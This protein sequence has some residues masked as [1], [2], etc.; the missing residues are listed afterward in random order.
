MS[1]KILKRIDYI[2]GML[3]I[4]AIFGM[5]IY[6]ANIEIKDLDL[7]LHLA[8]GKHITIN[9]FIPTF[10]FL[11]CSLKF[12]EWV[13]HEWLFQIL[14]YNIFDRWGA[15]GLLKMQAILVAVTMGFLLLLGYS[16]ERQILTSLGL[17]LVFLVYHQR[18]TIRPDLFSLLFFA[19]YIFVLALHIDKKWALPVLFFVQ[20]LWSNMHGFFFFGPLFAMIGVISELL[21]RHCWL[22]WEWNDSGR[23]ND[24]EYSRLKKILFFGI[25][26]CLVNPQFVKGA[27]Y[28]LGVFFS[29]SGESEIFFR[30]IQELQKPILSLGGILNGKYIYYKLLIVV[31]SVSFVLNRRRIDISALLFWIVFLI[32]SLKAVRNLPF[33]AFAAYLVI[34][35]N[36]LNVSFENVIPLK[37]NKKKF[38]FITSIFFKILILLWIIQYFQLRAQMWYYDIDKYERKSE[39]G[40]ISKRSYP[41]KGADFLIANNIEGNFFNDF[42]AGAYLLGRT[43]PKIKVF[44]D[45]RTEVYGGAYFKNYLKLWDHGNKA[46]FEKA[47]KEYDLTGVF[48]SSVKQHI[49]GKLLK[50]LYSSEQ[51]KLVYLNYES[52]IFLKDVEKNRKVIDEYEIDLD[53][54]NIEK[55]DLKKVGPIR[56]NPQRNYYRAYTL[57]SLGF[58]DAALAEAREALRIDPS[59]G[60][61]YNLIGKIYAKRK[62]FQLAF[63][64]FRIAAINNPGSRST[65]MNLAFSYFDLKDYDGAVKRYQKIIK[66]WPKAAKPYFYLSKTY[67][68]KDSLE[69]AWKVLETVRKIVPDDVFGVLGVGNAFMEREMYEE[70]FK[71]FSLVLG[72]K[73]YQDA[74]LVKL[75]EVLEKQGDLDGAK[76]KFQE[77][78]QI[79]SKNTDASKQLERINSLMEKEVEKK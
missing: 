20:I 61:S 49:S 31:S 55:M 48:L 68:M 46:V 66:T 43:H 73:V 74:V 54:W 77:A 70:A 27:L 8:V 53:N 42:N 5:L 3:P 52:V 59:Y 18:F 21:K 62:S 63:D 14:V 47:V 12:K 75:G 39:F 6:M 28:P 30:H 58:E 44:I 51:W 78:I 10:D 9:H 56:I 13:N 76:N 45:G 50:M 79:N 72:K 7:W 67:V 36:F 64:N 40:G 2:V 15:D 32:F 11:S 35:T 25:L 29:L 41:D 23:L 69:D 24:E 34:I 71:V 60:K 1:D 38:A 57:E 17:L 19:I 16:K 22:P 4:G 26:A 37:F 65:Q 33:F